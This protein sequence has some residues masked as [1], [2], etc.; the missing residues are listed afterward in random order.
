M[1]QPVFSIIIPTFNSGKTIRRAIE[2]VLTQ[3]F[4]RFELLLIDGLSTDQTVE[5][6]QSFA[7]QEERIHFVSEKDAGIFDA[8]N[9]GIRQA[10]GDWIYFMGSDDRLHSTYVLERIFEET[11]KGHYKLIY[12]HIISEK[13]GLYGGPVNAGDIIK[14]NI[15]HQAMFF[16]K[17]LFREY[18]FYNLEY[19]TH[20]DWEF[21]LRCFRKDGLEM[22]YIDLAIA[23]YA[24]GGA[25]SVHEV[26][27]FRRILL[28]ERLR[29]LDIENQTGIKSVS[30][31]D[32]WW[33]FIRN[34]K[35]KTEEEIIPF[36]LHGEIN[37]TIRLI[38]R[39]QKNLSKKILINGV[40]SKFFMALTY[41][42][43]LFFRLPNKI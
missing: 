22:K 17:C 7:A 40:S 28:P 33:R 38:I 14:K 39:A 10:A 15:S 31:F 29:Q 27:F 18:G 23:N 30:W 32:E 11:E 41:L 6:L 36:T 8:M 34:A 9:K 37:P 16:N 3:T 25:S 26:N 12:G 1:D 5:I 35:I 19:K 13:Y 24:S 43:Y 4:S 2:S 42:R 21:N 20:A